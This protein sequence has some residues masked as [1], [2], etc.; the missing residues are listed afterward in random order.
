MGD[1]KGTLRRERKHSVLCP[2]DQR[3][4]KV[5]ICCKGIL[6]PHGHISDLF[7]TL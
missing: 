4:H 3:I 2:D 7:C 6:Q 5:C 1:R